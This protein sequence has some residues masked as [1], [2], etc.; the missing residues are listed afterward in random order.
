MNKFNTARNQQGLTLVEA[1]ITLA[2]VCVLAGSALPGLESAR[3]RRHLEGAAAQLET[4]LQHARFSAV[5]L[6][7]AVRVSFNDLAGGGG[8]YVIH[9]GGPGDCVCGTTAPVCEDGT[10]VLRSASFPTDAPLAM[11]SSS[12]SIGFSAHNGSVTP[13]G[14]IELRNR[15]NESIK[16]V[17][18]IMGRVRSCAGMAPLP[19]LPRC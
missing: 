17:V 5:A 12:R 16:L 3:A 10:Q 19:S 9:T 13:S 2:V 8:C 7:Q 11:S 6:N 18:N 15:R 1:A 4:E 14:T